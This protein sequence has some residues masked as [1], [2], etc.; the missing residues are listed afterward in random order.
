MLCTASVFSQSFISFKDVRP[1]PVPNAYQ[2][3]VKDLRVNQQ[4]ALG[5]LFVA[6]GSK[7]KAFFKNGLSNTF[8][9][10]FQNTLKQD[11]SKPLVVLA[12]KNVKINEVKSQNL[13]NGTCEMM[14]EFLIVKGTETQKIG[15]IKN[16]S[17]FQRSVNIQTDEKL[18]EIFRKFIN[19]D[20]NYLNQWFDKNKTKHEGLAKGSKVIILPAYT[21]NE[22]DTVYYG[23]REINW[24]DF[25]GSPK[26]NSP[27]GA[28]IFT[29]IGY[30][31]EF[32]VQDGKIIAKITPKTFMIKGMSWTLPETKNSY[33]L[34]HE[35]LHFDIANLATKRFLKK[36]STINADTMD[37][38]NSRIQYEYLEAFKEMT[39]MQEQY[40]G[41][42]N[43]SL[44]AAKQSEW[45]AKVAVWL[46]E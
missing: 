10:F 31:S 39:R 5:E 24:D 9:Q 11:S 17:S 41:E 21:K 36:I 4:E 16:E 6:N 37:D 8:N 32:G 13:I 2:I 18:E 23:T 15:E 29:S 30:N 19:Q 28:M 45:A 44:I 14:L 27:Y 40:D 42:S 3:Q 1:N 7:Q 34:S 46:K 12:I 26:S 35:R 38:L 22:A 20:I 43:H 25:R 33:A